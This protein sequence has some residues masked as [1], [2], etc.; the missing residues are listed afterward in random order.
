MSGF[1]IVRHNKLKSI[2]HVQ[3]AINHNDRTT[4][5]KNADPSRLHLNHFK[6]DGMAK[7]RTNLASVTQAS[8]AKEP[9]ALHP[10]YSGR[11]RRHA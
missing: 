1:V 4:K 6:G 10:P 5:P 7:L 3:A 11:N 2:G 8:T 9:Y